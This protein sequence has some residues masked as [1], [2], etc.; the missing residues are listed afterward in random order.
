MPTYASASSGYRYWALA[1]GTTVRLEFNGQPGQW[2]CS[3]CYAVVNELPAQ[4]FEQR[5][6]LHTESHQP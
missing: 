3:E 6:Q 1:P 2:Q 4:T 5:A